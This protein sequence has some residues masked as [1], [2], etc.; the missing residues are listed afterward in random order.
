MSTHIS[1]IQQVG[2]GIPNVHE[3]WKWYRQHLG[4]DVPIFEEAAT[5]D[6]MLPYTGG[7]PHDRHAILALSM[8]GGGGFEIWQY[9]S[10]VPEPPTFLP[11]LGDLGIFICRMKSNN[12]KKAFDKLNA[13][14]MVMSDGIQKAPDGR[15]HFIIKDIYNNYFDIV[16]F[17][18]FFRKTDQP[19]GGVSGVAVGVSDMDKSM[20]FYSDI[21]GYDRVV[22]DET[23][24]F[25]DLG[26]VHGGEKEFRRVLLRHSK[27]RQG[28]F[29]KM[30]GSTEIELF[31]L[32]E[33]GGR[34]LFKDRFWGDLGYIHLCF[35]VTNMAALKEECETGG[36]KFTVDSANSF[37]MGEAAGHFTYTEDP[38][39]TLIE[40]VETHKIPILKK[41]G[42]YLDLRKR[43]PKKS[44]PNWMLRSLSLN[45][46][47]D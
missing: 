27:P 24:I 8:Q 33:G 20:K 15:E 44:L 43:D 4:M 34:K 41:I 45:R 46:K 37:D 7:K 31:Q 12:I 29:S 35:D 30:L 5:A 21:L 10:R 3:A 22:Y 39:G 9:T 16:E 18:D 13:E 26:G 14:G 25:K 47:K 2:I 19:S 38:D 23:G 28:A 32:V 1:G 11:D 17:D 36:H 6:L 42:W 40:F